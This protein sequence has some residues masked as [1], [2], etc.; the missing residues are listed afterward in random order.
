VCCDQIE[1]AQKQATLLT[2]IV[3]DD[4]DLTSRLSADLALL[5][6]RVDSI[7]DSV[8]NVQH[9]VDSLETRVEQLELKPSARKSV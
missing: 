7:A 2:K 3:H 1:V 4:P 5:H 8:E 6:D 9:Q